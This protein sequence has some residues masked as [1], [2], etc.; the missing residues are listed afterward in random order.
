MTPNEQTAEILRNLPLSSEVKEQPRIITQNIQLTIE[1]GLNKL[2]NWIESNDYKGYDPADG[3]TSYLRPLTCGSLFLDRLLQQLIWRSPINIRPILGVKPKDSFIARG[4]MASGYLLQYKTTKDEKYLIKAL[5]CLEHLKSNKAPGYEDYCWGKTHDFASRGGRQNKFEPITIWTSL[6]GSA[7][8]DAYDL[9]GDGR[10]LQ[11][12]ES[13]CDWISKMPRNETSSGACI[14]YTP[15]DNGS[16]VHNQSMVAAAL[17]ARAHKL[18]GNESYLSLAREAIIY[19]C[20]R[21][22]P[23]GSWWYGE[24]D[25]YHWIDNFHTA[26]NLDA[27]K[28]YIEQ[29][30][31]TEYMRNLAKGFDFYKNHFFEPNGRP[32]YYHS[33]AYPIDSQCISQSIETLVNF[34]EVDPNS[35]ELAT[36]VAEW[37]I[38][39][40]QDK[41]GYFYYAQYPFYT[42]KVPLI[43]WAQATTYKALALLLHK[44]DRTRQDTI[45]SLRAA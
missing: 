34:S 22:R 24:E 3:L 38:N 18:T 12:V 31:E 29:T 25:K 42:V 41:T 37:A 19:S 15:R 26:Y 44:L 17:L 40:M 14:A 16:V 39:N 7:F 43:H 13:V 11:V 10:H 4:Y 21:Q 20:T 2:E 32:K 35:F 8:F 1:Q 36:A 33:R 27:L 5:Q 30:G 23:D 28:C 45:P 6:I 9:T